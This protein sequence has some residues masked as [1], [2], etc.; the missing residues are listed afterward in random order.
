MKDFGI[1]WTPFAKYEP[2]YIRCSCG[3]EFRS[4]VKGIMH[5]DSFIVV[6]RTPC[7]DCGSNSNVRQATSP[8]ESYGINREDIRDVGNRSE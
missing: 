4:H 6:T 2:N 8:R 7:P 5:E 1:D 3:G